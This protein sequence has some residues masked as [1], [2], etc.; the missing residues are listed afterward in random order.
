MKPSRRNPPRNKTDANRTNV[1]PRE[2]QNHEPQDTQDVNSMQM[3]ILQEINNMNNT[4][5]KLRS[6]LN[7]HSLTLLT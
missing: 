4:M 3:A 1:D 5:N 2:T 6:D 7:S